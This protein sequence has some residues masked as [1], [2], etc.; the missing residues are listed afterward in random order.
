MV[1]HHMVMDKLV[2]L[3]IAPS[4]LSTL[5]F[6]PLASCSDSFAVARQCSQFRSIYERSHIKFVATFSMYATI[7]GLELVLMFDQVV[8]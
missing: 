6:W 2:S 1:C 5:L 8:A 7:S 4:P 3:G